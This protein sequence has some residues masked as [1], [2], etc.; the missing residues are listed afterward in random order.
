[1]HPNTPLRFFSL[2]VIA[3]LVNSCNLTPLED[4]IDN[5]AIVIELPE[6]ETELSFQ[7]IDATTKELIEQPVEVMFFGGP[8]GDNTVIDMYSDEITDFST[9]T[10][11]MN[12]GLEN[13]TSI[14]ASSPLL[15]G[16]KL[17]ASGYKDQTTSIEV[18]KNGLSYY[19]VEMIPLFNPPVGVSI[20]NQTLDNVVTDGVLTENLSFTTSESSGPTITT[21]G[22]DLPTGT[23]L[24]DING[25]PLSGQLSA[26]VVIYNTSVPEVMSLISPT[27]FQDEEDSTRIIYGVWE[28][29]VMDQSGRVATSM[30][31][32]AAFKYGS[33]GLVTTISS[34][35]AK[36]LPDFMT[37]PPFNGNPLFQNPLWWFGT[38]SPTPPTPIITFEFEPLASL[39]SWT[40]PSYGWLEGFDFEA[41]VLGSSTLTSPQNPSCS[42]NSPS[43]TTTVTQKTEAKDITVNIDRN[44]HT[45]PL[46][47]TLTSKG[48]LSDAVELVDESSVE[49][50]ATHAPVTDQ[51][52][53]VKVQIAALPGDVITKTISRSEYESGEVT[54]TLPIAEVSLLDAPLKV[55]LQCS[56]PDENP[57]ISDIP[58]ASLYYRLS[59]AEAGDGF[60]P[61]RPTTKIEFTQGS[62]VRFITGGTTTLKG[63]LPTKNYEFKLV[64]NDEVIT[65]EADVIPT[66]AGGGTVEYTENLSDDLCQ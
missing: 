52:Y 25:T 40:Q 49:F 4:A 42:G 64:Y 33:C 17:T 56:N 7:I 51:D 22:F 57:T 9:N 3:G 1:M 55:N 63:V 37:A 32:P 35:C 12:V 39:P 23:V 48:G 26:E 18:R 19:V 20:V 5:F 31:L 11:F 53:T 29:K 66:P 59:E 15:M 10:G 13:G 41:C 65:R 44:G 34:G 16:I 46:R 61:W 27:L 60:N 14:S 30:E 54:I 43:R 47:V 50:G 24:K 8:S 28:T 45:S 2:I 62:P 6:I 38:P 36:Q 21:V 58:T